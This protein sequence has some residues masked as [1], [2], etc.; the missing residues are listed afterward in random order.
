ME[1]LGV[2]TPWT[3]INSAVDVPVTS[4]SHHIS[5]PFDWLQKRSDGVLMPQE[6]GHKNGDSTISLNQNLCKT[7]PVVQAAV[8]KLSASDLIA[9]LRYNRHPSHSE[10]DS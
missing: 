7:D 8:A 2:R 4:S 5:S 10:L 3:A 6:A 9:S 1:D